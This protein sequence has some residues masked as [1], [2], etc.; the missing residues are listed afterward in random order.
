VDIQPRSDPVARA[1]ELGAQ[2]AAA[3]DEIERTQRIP[4]ALLNRLHDSRL[5]RML[6]SRSSGG[7]E[8]APAVYAAAIE[9]LARHDASIAWNVFVANSSSL[10]AACLEPPTAT[11]FQKGRS[12]NPSGGPKKS[13]PPL[14]LGVILEE[15]E[16]EEI[17]VFDNGKRKSMKKAEIHFR[18]QFT[19]AING[20]LPTARLLVQMAEEYFA[21]EASAD[22]VP[23]VI[24]KTEAQRRFGSNWPKKID[25]LN[26]LCGSGQ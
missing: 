5:F 7:D 1:R 11:R 20:D 17:I 26:A 4:E 12:G 24:G 10:I 23:E 2:I 9:E 21:P 6:L 8:T 14:D 15:I 3:A 13:A 25:E 16:N 19:K 22:G 18:Q